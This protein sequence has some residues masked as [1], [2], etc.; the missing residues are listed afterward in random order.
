MSRAVAGLRSLHSLGYLLVLCVDQQRDAADLGCGEKIPPARRE[1]ELPA[2]ALLLESAIHGQAREAKAWD[3]VAGQAAADSLRGA[4]VLDSGG[5]QDVEAEDCPAVAPGEREKSL[6][7]A[8]F[9][10][11]AGVPM[12]ELVERGFTAITSLPVASL[13]DRLFVPENGAHE[14]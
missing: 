5:A 6:C 3:V 10:A 14:C 12:Q 4:G 9:V 11:L 7:A 8:Q 2:E 1:Q 13:A